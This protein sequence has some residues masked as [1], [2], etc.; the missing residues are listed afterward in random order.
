MPR[1]SRVRQIVDRSAIHSS[2]DRDAAK[3]TN[4]TAHRRLYSGTRRQNPF[5]LSLHGRGRR[6]KTLRTSCLP[7]FAV[8]PVCFELHRCGLRFQ[9]RILLPQ[10]KQAIRGACL[11]HAEIQRARHQIFL[12]P[13]KFDPTR[14][15]PAENPCLAPARISA[16]SQLHRIGPCNSSESPGP[17]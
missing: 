7:I 11:Q 10:S 9:R 13:S 6:H 3:P 5:D 14:G 1:G 8:Q 4:E 17:N 12:A 15:A 16:A 2:V